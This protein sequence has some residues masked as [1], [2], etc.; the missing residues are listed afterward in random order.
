M[1]CYRR[2][3][4]V[5]DYFMA[6]APYAAW[7]GY[8]DHILKTGT[9]GPG[10]ENPP[11]VLDLACGTGGITLP[12]ARRGYDMI[13]VDRSPD[14]LTVARDKADRKKLSILF[15]AQ[16]MRELDLYGTVDAALCVCDG[17]NYLLT[18]A[19]LAEVFVRVARF[20]NP[21]GIFIFDMNTEYK[22]KMILSGNTFS[23]SGR[24]ASYRWQN[25]YDRL[26]GIN[27]YTLHFTVRGPAGRNEHFNETHRQRAYPADTVHTLLCG[28]GLR[29]LQVNDAYTDNAPAHNSERLSFIAAKP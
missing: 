6:E 17:L 1:A 14:M 8:I 29:L 2:F 27:E 4:H 20:L 22:F 18:E 13:G 3:A 25:H 16:D 15:L 12:L 26:T 10:G 7:A 9:R 11:L 19:E 24:E 23:E 28:A 21:G 5:Y